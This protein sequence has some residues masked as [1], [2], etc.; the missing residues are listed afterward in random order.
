MNIKQVASDASAPQ[1]SNPNI[2]TAMAA[3]EKNMVQLWTA[4]VQNQSAY[5]QAFTAIDVKFSI[6]LRAMNDMRKEELYLDEAGAIDYERY[7][8][9]FLACE[10]FAKA[11]SVLQPPLEEEKGKGHILQHSQEEQPV[12]F[13]GE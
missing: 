5:S 11:V 12:I 6:L 3:L 13:G 9:E 4:Q 2:A 7:A 1:G 10:A 8:K